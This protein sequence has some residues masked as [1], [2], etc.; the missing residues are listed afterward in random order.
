MSADAGHFAVLGLA[1][2]GAVW[3]RDLGRWATAGS[4]PVE[5]TKCVTVGEV[6][7]LLASGRAWSAVLI[8]AGLPALDRDLVEDAR[9]RGAA[10]LV[11]GDAGRRDL[12]SLGV[13]AEV[14]EPVS[15]AAL[16]ATLR[17]HAPSLTSVVD[18]PP[19]LVP[20]PT[21]D[22]AW[23]GRL[24]AVTGGGGTGRSV[25][26]MAIAQALAGDPRLADGVV[27]ADLALDA[28]QAVLHHAGDVVP[29]LLELVDAHRSGTV[30][31]EGLRSLTW[32]VED[33]GYRLVLGLRRHRDW[34][35]LRPRAVAAA[36]ASLTAHARVVIADVD[37]DLEGEQECGS[38][39]VEDR[40]LLARTVLPRADL[41]V[42]TG[43][44]GIVGLHRLVTVVAG[45]VAGGVD[46]T[47]VLPVVNRAPR[48]GRARAEVARAVASL[49]AGVTGPAGM[50]TA[51]PVFVPERRALD[52]AVRDAGPLPRP[53]VAPLG[54]AV[55][56]ALRHQEPSPPA[57]PAGPVP[58]RPGSL[59][60]VP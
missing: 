12:A 26:A 50:V 1:R 17:G 28:T 2:A 54:S 7:A 43:L 8:D 25:V 45:L 52:D 58:V 32:A 51:G 21:L 56:A 15:P 20:S 41:V 14:A 6:R 11:V 29:G 16:L 49:T 47:R 55:L 60:L 13:T 18:A 44:P 23:R 5:F 39:D 10:V 36:L 40:N 9:R 38:V 24:V 59:G 31:A 27:L 22:A 30:D 42:V 37:A 4:V 34:T 19:H 3:F 33:R 35:A 57:P 46:P 48:T 53:F